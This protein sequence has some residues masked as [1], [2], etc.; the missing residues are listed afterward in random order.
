MKLWRYGRPI[1]S[2]GQRYRLDGMLGSGGMADVCLAWDE[3]EGREAAVKILKSDDLDQ[4]TLN[5]FMKEAAQIAGWQHPNILR[6]YESMQIELI[7]AAQGSVLFYMVTEY[8]R[9]GDLHKRLSPGRPFPPASTFA[10][11]RQLCGAVQYAHEQGIIHRDLKPLNI[12]FRRPER[13]SEEVVLSDFGLAVQVDASHHTFAR[14]GTLA[15]MA[16]EQFQGHALPA[17]DIFALGVILYQLCTG[18]LPFRRTIQDI[19]RMIDVPAPTPMRPSLLNPELP[20]AL[21]EIILRALRELPTERYRGAQEFWD[22]IALALVSAA[23]TFPF[24]ETAEYAAGQT[25]PIG[26]SEQSPPSL[27]DHNSVQSRGERDTTAASDSLA[28]EL[29]PP[30]GEGPGSGLGSVREKQKASPGRMPGL[31]LPSYSIPAPPNPPVQFAPDA[32]PARSLQIKDAQRDKIAEEEPRSMAGA[33]WG[34]EIAPSTSRA[35]R[36]SP[37]VS[38]TPGARSNAT[39]KRNRN[40]EDDPTA[41]VTPPLAR[42]ARETWDEDE[43]TSERRRPL[44]SIPERASAKHLPGSRARVSEA[45]ARDRAGTRAAPTMDGAYSRDTFFGKSRK[46]PQQSMPAFPETN[47]DTNPSPVHSRGGPR[48]RSAHPRP[49]VAHARSLGLHAHPRSP[50]SRKLPL[51]PTLTALALLVLLVAIVLAAGSQGWLLRLFGAPITTVT[52]TPRS[53]LVQQN[54]MLTAVLTSPDPARSQVSTRLLTTTSPTR[55]ATANATGSIAAKKAT[56]T[57]VFINN[58]ASTITIRTTTI[59]GKSGVSVSFNGPVTITATNP[60]TTVVAFAVN[61]GA[62]GNIPQFDIDGPCCFNG[63]VVKNTAFTGGQ[64]AQPNSIIEQ[65]DI[66][67]AANGLIASLKPGTLASLQGM[68]RNSERVITGSQ[69]CQPQTGADHQAGAVAKTVTVQVALACSEQVYDYGAARQIAL[70]A[71]QAQASSDLHLGAAYALDGQIVLT[72]LNASQP[73]AHGSVTL[74]IQAS[75]L[76]VYTFSQA[77]LRQLAALIAGKSESAARALLLAQPGIAAVQFHPSSTNA[78]PINTGEIQL[79]LQRLPGATPAAI[80]TS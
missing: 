46:S 78:L 11:F 45:S 16:P 63:I 13:G 41:H 52:L 5:R 57:L 36:T 29:A 14:G 74:T 1:E 59:T 61:P 39:F 40:D 60:S 3:R 47:L 73:D 75:G 67:G 38:H 10:L 48:A 56:G 37:R 30:A 49:L 77:T 42:R 7:D 72:Q 54:L 51:V 6:I 33:V 55:T 24:A 43:E 32:A 70:R 12:L 25:W 65:K 80:G 2:L 64:D 9:G 8:A 17:S 18:Y 26:N 19:S 27:A 44:S 22:A 68:V 66:D 58:T 23:P 76:W 71:L 20:G 4:E 62:N 28:A 31:S 53:Q 21:D 34:E 50:R 79:T 35:P 69:Q 15:Y